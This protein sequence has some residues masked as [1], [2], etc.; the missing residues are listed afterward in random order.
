MTPLSAKHDVAKDDLPKRSKNIL[1]VLVKHYIDTGEPVS[2]LWLAEHGGIELSSASVRNIMCDLE[3]RGYVNQPHKSAGRIPTDHGYRCFVDSILQCRQESHK[4]S[5]VEARLR[6]A[7]TVDDILSNV[8]HELSV[9]SHHLGFAFLPQTSTENL[10]RID[11][12]P[13]DGTRI[14]VVVSTQGGQIAHKSI[15]LKKAIDQKS[16][17][18][19]ANYLNREFSG[20]PLRE[21]RS[22]IISMLR[23]DRMLYDELLSSALKLASSTLEEIVPQTKLFFEGAGF[24][25]EEVSDHDDRVPLGTL[26]SLLS[27]I[28]RK[29][30]LVRLLNEYIDGAELTVVIGTEHPSPDMQHFSLV[31]ST[32][33]DGQRTGSIGVIGP[34]RMRYS[35]T[36]AVV[37]RVSQAVSRVLLSQTT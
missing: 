10:E 35:R 31:T 26:R 11:F 21:V 7:G 30:L 37:D 19:G 36:I 16:L 3:E 22:S 25:A 27:M 29:E 6:Q 4:T 20:R 24:L 34:R 32:Y 23:Q 1:A 18:L 12:V 28:E 9:A 33:F 13:V 8:S 14:L 17:T 15:D 5:A 2:S